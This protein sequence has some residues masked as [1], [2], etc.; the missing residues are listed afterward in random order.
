MSRMLNLSWMAWSRAKAVSAVEPATARRHWEQVV[1]MAA[2]P[3]PELAAAHRSLAAGHLRSA[4]YAEARRHL[5]SAIELQPNCT[6][7]IRQLARVWEDDPY[8]DD[9]RAARAYRRA[10]RVDPNDAIAWASLGRA[11][12]RIGRNRLAIQSI[13]RAVRL[14]P[15]D[16]RVL[17]LVVDALRESGKLAAA[18]RIVGRARFLN[19]RSAAIREYGDRIRYEIARTLRPTNPSVAG[20]TGPNLLPFVRVVGSDGER[21]V[22]R[23]DEASRPVPVSIRFRG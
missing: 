18:L 4:R 2:L 14:A 12:V 1:A 19:P 6:D 21:R 15:S 3:E 8:G 13:R 20:S 7:T 10:T 23:R 9:L 11:A 17:S 22:V 16:E 5:R